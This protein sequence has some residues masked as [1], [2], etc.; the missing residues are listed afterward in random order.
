MTMTES[1]ATEYRDLPVSLLFESDTNPRRY[2]DEAFLKELAES[3]CTHGVLSPL[4]VRPKG[5]RFE[6][7]FAHSVI[8]QRRWPML[9]LSR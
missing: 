7:V 2:F 6:I 5:E 8:A 9:Q 1:T 4:L 3:I